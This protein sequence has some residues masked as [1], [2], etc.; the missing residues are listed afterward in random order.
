MY[1]A[2]IPNR[3][4][5]P[6]V[7][8]RES[9]REGGKVKKRTL[10]NLSALAPQHVEV[11][12]RAL[13]GQTLVPAEGAFEILRSRPHGHVAAVLGTARKL[14]LAEILSGRRQ[15][16]RDLAL[17][18]IV[19]RVLEPASKLATARQLGTDTLSSTLGEILD[20]G[21]AEADDLY[22]AMDWLVK[23]QGRIEKKLARRH[24]KEGDLVL[25][26][27]TSSYFEGRHC[28]LAR[29]GYSRD[30]RRDRS[31]V[32]FGVLTTADGCP[33]AVEAFP[34]NTADPQT[35]G[36]AV[37]RLRNRFQLD[38]M[39]MVG[40]RGLVTQ[41]RIDQDLRPQ[42]IRWVS[43]LRAPQI[44]KLWQEG[45]LQLSLFDQQDLAEITS[46]D[47][48]GE[49]LIACRNPFLAE[50]RARK[51]EDLL[52][53]TE[54]ELE[55]VRAATLR[56]RRPLRGKAQIGLRVGKVLGRYKV[57]KHFRLEIAEN[58]LDFARDAERIEEEAALDGIYV[59]RTSVAAETLS[60]EE[61]VRTYKR[62]SVVERAFRAHKTSGLQVRPIHHRREDRVR[63]H[64]FLCMLA[65]YVQWH[66]EQ[67]WAPL[68][69]ADHEP[70][71]AE[72]RRASVVGPAQRSQAAEQKAQRKK[73]ADGLPVHSFRTLLKDLG[74]LTLN[75]L[76]VGDH[77][78]YQ[79]IS[80]PT[81]LQQ[82]ALDLLGVTARI[83]QPR[84]Q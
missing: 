19:A 10:A 24:L 81:V 20:V 6:A 66:M 61:A 64:L 51:R 60:A 73:T 38:H 32:V 74:T 1:I 7:L 23:G 78:S 49:R 25:W 58:Q 9:Y 47:F 28:P 83:E 84:S 2:T 45:P 80:R 82:R 44:R 65:Y 12:R 17:A 35:L 29:L 13:K 41:A 76:A 33:V 18:M 57:G 52:Q 63:A 56:E 14:G 70:A 50:E 46:S 59:V 11:L 53:A 31:Q 55:K 16:M 42:G 34:G 37:E 54:G 69:F 43:S 15:R 22:E 27:V 39:V 72:A 79:Q 4:S 48:P 77:I 36:A 30:G 21:E 40:D 68:L 5:P 75:T 26:D 71:E 62:L 67:Q 8:L 3:N